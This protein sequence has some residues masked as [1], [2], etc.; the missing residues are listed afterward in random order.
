MTIEEPQETN[1]VEAAVVSMILV[2]HRSSQDPS[3]A[4]A[5]ANE[6][7]RS[8]LHRKPQRPLKIFVE[9]LDGIRESCILAN[10]SGVVEPVGHHSR[11]EEASSQ[12]RIK[13][14]P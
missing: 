6:R 5:G 3:I 8:V 1:W 12:R 2:G 9:G 4:R 11:V 7:R 14:R 13:R 10:G